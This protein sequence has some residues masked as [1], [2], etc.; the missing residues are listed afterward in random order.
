[1]RNE[2][3]FT[4]TLDQNLRDRFIAGADATLQASEN[5]LRDLMRTSW[6]ASG[7]LAPR[8]IVTRVRH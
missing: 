2:A 6:R 8:L 1:M 4:L 7:R 3:T 5:V